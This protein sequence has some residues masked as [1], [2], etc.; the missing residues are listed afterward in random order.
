MDGW[1]DG[2]GPLQAERM[3][4]KFGYFFSFYPTAKEKLDKSKS[5]IP[6]EIHKSGKG[7]RKKES[8]LNKRMRR[9]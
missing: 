7:M 1:I 4:G 9:W 8:G 2:F 6:S 3:W 5:K